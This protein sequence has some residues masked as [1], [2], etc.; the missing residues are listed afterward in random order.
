MERDNF[1]HD[2]SKICCM[3]YW[4]LKKTVID[5]FCNVHVILLFTYSNVILKGEAVRLITEGRAPSIVQSEEGATYDAMLK[6]SLVEVNKG[7]NKITK[8]R[9]VLQKESQ[10][11]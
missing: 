1:C 11:S 10:N 5:L 3:N 7:N 9:T 6:K 8:L 4:Q 2:T